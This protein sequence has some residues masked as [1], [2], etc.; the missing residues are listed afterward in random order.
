MTCLFRWQ[1][2]TKQTNI[3]ATPG[4]TGFGD[5]GSATGD[6]VNGIITAAPRL[7][8][9][10]MSMSNRSLRVLRAYDSVVGGDVFYWSIRP[11]PTP[12]SSAP[13][14]TGPWSMRIYVRMPA[15]TSSLS[16]LTF[17]EA[18][19][20]NL[21]FTRL[22]S[23]DRIARTSSGSG[24]TMSGGSNFHRL[25]VQF[26]PARTLNLVWR[27]YLEDG[28]VPLGGFQE[29]ITDGNWDEL[30]LGYITSGFFATQAAFG[31]I[32]IHD[33]YDLGGQFRSSPQDGT[34]PAST[35]AAGAPSWSEGVNAR[36]RPDSSFE[37]IPA[38]TPTFTTYSNVDYTTAG[39]F[40][41]KLDLYVPDGTPP[42]TGWPIACWAHSGF[43][44]ENDKN[45]L[46]TNWRD[47]L[48]LA[49][50]A[51]AT[52][53]Y[54]K[55]TADVSGG[56]DAYGTSNLG[57]RYPSFIIDYKRAAAFLR[58]NAATY[59]LDPARMFA[60]GYSAGGY[61]ALAAAMTRELAT[62]TDGNNMKLNGNGAAWADGYTGADPVFL[63]AYVY[64]APIDMDLAKAWDPTHPN[65]GSLIRK[66]T[67]RYFQG[68]ISNGTDAPDYPTQSIA[69]HISL[70][71]L[72]NLCP[73]AYERGTADMLIH[74]E[75]EAALS[76]ALSSKGVSYTAIT[77]PNMHDNANTLYAR[78]DILDWLNALAYPS[79]GSQTKTLYLHD[80]TTSEV[81]DEDY[82]DGSVVHKQ[83]YSR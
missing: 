43:F 82:H 28:T 38:G 68:L 64:A 37:T 13:T 11:T 29:T 61:I 62:D 8:I 49:G 83:L 10:N 55:T 12:W 15:P 45:T 27:V 18:T 59:D 58:D 14:I 4:L 71:T 20:A 32:E 1:G 56:Y 73:V 17:R 31:D 67:Y 69:D 23:A 36:Y 42:A 79:D 41:R 80:G 7:D 51:V 74:E 34:T 77:T 52:I 65:C 21:G 46:P 75:H 26:D 53:Q 70:N 24:V 19:V 44:S 60:T 72:G 35:T 3:I 66:L 48:L 30:R 76:A 81:V 47:D 50:Y 6:S 40:N 2:R 33:N 78:E 16:F 9:E 22:I 39:T 54:V 25:E 63:G 5:I 57:G